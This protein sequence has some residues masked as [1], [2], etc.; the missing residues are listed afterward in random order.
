MRKDKG[1]RR[2]RRIVWS[3]GTQILLEM[4]VHGKVIK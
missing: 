3:M 2:R 4:V 1:G